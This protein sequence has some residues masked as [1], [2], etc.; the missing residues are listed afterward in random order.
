M[1]YKKNTLEDIHACVNYYKTSGL[2]QQECADD[3]NI[4]VSTLKYHLN[5]NTKISKIITRLENSPNYIPPSKKITSKKTLKT[6]EWM[7]NQNIPI[8]DISTE[9]TDKPTFKKSS[10][11]SLEAL[12]QR[13]GFGSL[14][15]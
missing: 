14:K 1:P 7:K 11:F 2:T 15:K 4:P 6:L 5:K 13:L 12:N 8:Q 10:I 3:H 9:T